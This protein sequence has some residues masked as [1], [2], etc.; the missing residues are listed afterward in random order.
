MT[1]ATI[2][3][4]CSSVALALLY[5]SGDPSRSYYGADSRIHEILI[6]SVLALLM[7]RSPACLVRL[8]TEH[9]WTVLAPT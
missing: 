2:A 4:L 3:V 5:S 8:V 7:K 6:G 9:R 1:T